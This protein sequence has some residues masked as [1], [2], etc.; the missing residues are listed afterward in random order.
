MLEYDLLGAEF[1]VDPYPT[2]AEMRRND[3]CWFDHRL[4]AYVLTGYDDVERVL[5]DHDFSAQ[6]VRQFTRGAPE[7]LVS[8]VEAYVAALERWL[9]FVDPPH[10][11]A[12]RARLQGAFGPRLLPVI[13]DAAEDAIRTALD[14]IARQRAPDVIAHFAYPVPTTVLARVFGISEADIERFK[15]WTVDIFTLVGAG[16]ANAAAVEAGY[17]GVVGLRAYVLALIDEKRQYP[18]D[19]M[20]S[21]LAV[22]PAGHAGERIGRGRRRGPVHE[23]DRGRP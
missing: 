17:R 8:K 22:P 12:L 4:G 5:Q 1:Y 19:D 16:V 15:Q 14:S 9:L 10:H 23:H 18:A 7:H 13:V 11:T 3:P 20:L 2:L 21:A 6:R